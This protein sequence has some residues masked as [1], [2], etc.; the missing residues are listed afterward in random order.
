MLF[1]ERTNFGTRQNKG[2]GSFTIIKQIKNGKEIEVRF[3]NAGYKTYFSLAL[4]NNNDWFSKYKDVSERMNLL[5][6]AIRSGINFKNRDRTDKFYF[7]SLMFL[8]AKEV[9]KIQW[10]K[11]TIKEEFFPISR[12]HLRDGRELYFNN[13][14]DEQK[15]NR[16]NSEPLHYSTENKKLFKDLLGLSSEESW[17]S[18]RSNISKVQARQ[19]RGR[20]VEESKKEN[21]V[22][23][24]F[25][26]PILFKPILRANDTIRVYVFLDQKSLDEAISINKDFIIKNE[27]E[28]FHLSFPDSFSLND[29]FN[30]ILD[31]NKFNISTYVETRYQNENEYKVLEKIFD[32]LRTNK[33]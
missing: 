31:T 8:Y 28:Q 11:K 17:Y 27:R 22:F 29:F 2:F 19:D 4:N 12:I 13:R 18:Y 20:W 16:P 30:F 7:K 23:E 14:L 1:F 6:K 5:Y 32:D 15:E 24:R 10:E 25:K 33:L 21:I 3:S 9:Y 26:S